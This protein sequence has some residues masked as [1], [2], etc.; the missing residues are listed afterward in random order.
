MSSWPSIAKK[1]NLQ[2]VT[3]IAPGK[4][5]P[6]ITELEEGGWYSVSVLVEKSKVHT[7][8]DQLSNAGACDM[9]VTALQN[10]RM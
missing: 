4:R 6:T 2:A 7:L 3:S 9:L 10:T 5:S 1:D 8:M